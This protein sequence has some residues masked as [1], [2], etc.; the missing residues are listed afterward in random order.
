MSASSQPPPT[1]TD[2]GPGTAT[3]AAPGVRTHSGSR[4]YPIGRP[5]T[6]LP[7]A[8]RALLAVS[9][10]IAVL[11]ALLVPLTLPLGWDELVYA[12]RFPNFDPAT[13]FSSPRTRGVPLLLAPVAVWT[14][15]VVV[16]RLWL[17][18]LASAALYLGFRPWLRI[19]R[20]P[21]AVPLAAA[22]YG[23]LWISLFY[24]GSAMPNHYTAMGSLAAVGYFLHRRPPAAGIAL[25][26][27]VAT[28]MRP[29]DAVWIAGPLLV[30]ALLVPAWR[31]RSAL[32]GTVAGVALGALPWV[33]EAYARFDGVF[34]RLSDA[35]DVQG[36][37]RP[38]L[39]FVE[40]A[41][42]LDG[43]LLCRPCG[44]DTVGFTALELWLLL[45][46]FTVL[47]ILALRRAGADR[48]PY[49][50]AIGVALASAAPYFFLLDYAAPR[51]L[52]PTYALLLIPA[53]LGMLYAWDA[54]R[55]SDRRLPVVGLSLVLVAHLA[56][57]LPLA[58]HHAQVQTEARQ[59]WVRVA[60]LLHESGVRP[61]C[62]LKAT[63]RAIPL[64]HTAGCEV[65]ELTERTVPDAVVYRGAKP[66]PFARSWPTRVVP[67]V[68]AEGWAVAVR[69]TSGGG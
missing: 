4:P 16:L 47:G 46:V 36:G 63:A 40:N 26:L 13:P 66:P 45:P 55:R 31:R 21:K 65:V 69:P 5:R 2:R 27:A 24:T 41:T 49:W 54:A 20:R 23:T 43:P 3:P 61:P 9:A 25:G 28:L 10:G 15:S 67:E 6:P 11:A 59:D 52:L 12:S 35:S 32:Y 38:V 17:T 62:T 8:H 44:N 53:T 56:V 51:F 30:G 22:A 57:Q 39:S 7:R 33:V 68:Y 48:R 34:D 1:A 29:N 18:L 50:L 14:D 19:V 58:R 64:A 60:T 42:A 37:M